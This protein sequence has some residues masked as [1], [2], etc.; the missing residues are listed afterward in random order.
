MSVLDRTTVL[1]RVVAYLKVADL[2]LTALFGQLRRR[3]R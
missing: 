2:L 3:R 1:L